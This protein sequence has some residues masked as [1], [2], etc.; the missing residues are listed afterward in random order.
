MPPDAAAVHKIA[1]SLQ[2]IRL[3]KNSGRAGRVP[4]D[5]QVLYAV[6]TSNSPKCFAPNT[7]PTANT[8]ATTRPLF[9]FFCK[10]RK[11]KKR[12]W[13]WYKSTRP[14]KR[15]YFVPSLKKSSR[16]RSL[17]WRFISSVTTMSSGQ[18]LAMVARTKLWLRIARGRSAKVG[19]NMNK[20]FQ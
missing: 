11:K 19:V 2:C 1:F 14:G 10:K 16:Q 4:W 17:C 3:M 8:P 15:S 12:S 5:R 20:L 9:V 18:G 7:T 13:W 6:Q